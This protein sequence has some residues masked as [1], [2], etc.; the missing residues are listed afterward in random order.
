MEIQP[1]SSRLHNG[2]AVH[3]ERERISAVALADAGMIFRNEVSREGS[4]TYTA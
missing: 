2:S 1:Q 3:G 4:E